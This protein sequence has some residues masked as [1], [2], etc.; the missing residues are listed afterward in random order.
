[1]IQ[2]I[3]ITKI[4][5]KARFQPYFGCFYPAKIAA[6]GVEPFGDILRLPRLLQ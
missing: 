1:M 2:P 4:N 6:V 5:S 3:E